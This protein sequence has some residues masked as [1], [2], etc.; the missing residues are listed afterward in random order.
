M[1]SLPIAFLSLGLA[2]F[3]WGLFEHLFGETVR[4]V[5]RLSLLFITFGLIVWLG[6]S[7]AK[8]AKGP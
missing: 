1:K 5:V 4:L 6:G 8:R 3:L 7:L 2:A